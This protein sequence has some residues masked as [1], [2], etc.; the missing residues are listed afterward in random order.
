M[1]KCIFAMAAWAA[2]RPPFDNQITDFRLHCPPLY[3]SCKISL[4]ARSH[5]AF[6]PITTR[7]RSASGTA[8]YFGTIPSIMLET[9]WPRPQMGHG[10]LHNP[11]RDMVGNSL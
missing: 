9:L 10:E 1:I 8:T 5:E 4:V 7:L 11:C 2:P 6:D 3:F